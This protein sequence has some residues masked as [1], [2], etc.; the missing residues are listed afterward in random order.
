MNSPRARSL[1][2]HVHGNELQHAVLGQHADDD[3]AIRLRILVDQRQATR[4]GLNEALAGVEEGAQ[5]VNREER[6]RGYMEFA[7]NVWPCQSQVPL[8]A[9]DSKP[10]P[11]A[12]E[13][14]LLNIRSRAFPTGRVVVVLNEMNDV[15]DREH[16]RKGRAGSVPQRSRYD[17]CMLVIVPQTSRCSRR[18]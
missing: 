8:V 12:L 2:T 1:N 4:M 6:R 3:L 7:L 5:G 17:A 10:T 14:E 13:T 9:S 15:L 11:Q 16:A 18:W